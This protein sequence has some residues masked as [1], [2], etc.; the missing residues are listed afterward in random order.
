MKRFYFLFLVA[1][2]SPLIVFT[3]GA[4]VYHESLQKGQPA[5][6]KAVAPSVYPPIAKAAR[7]EGKVIVEVRV[8]TAG[9]V[10]SAKCVEG[11]KLLQAISLIAAKQ[12]RFVPSANGSGE[13]TARLTF[14]FRLKDDKV[15][16]ISF[17][18]PYEVEYVGREV[19]VDYTE[20]KG[21]A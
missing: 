2:L 12:W 14:S 1:V 7:A 8:S 17:I 20:S 21:A 10:L 9:E 15:D 4:T 16:T 3:A 18:P 6:T 5:V 11:L 19:V 13:R